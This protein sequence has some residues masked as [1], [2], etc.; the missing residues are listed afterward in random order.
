LTNDELRKAIAHQIANDPWYPQYHLTLVGLVCNLQSLHFKGR[1][2]YF[3][4]HRGEAMNHNEVFR[5]LA[6]D[7]LVSW[8]IKPAP[9]GWPHPIWPNGTLLVGAGGRPSIVGGYPITLATAEDD[10]L[11]TWKVRNDEV[12]ITQEH[13][14][15]VAEP[16]SAPG[17]VSWEEGVTWRAGEVFY[18]AGG[19]SHWDSVDEK[20]RLKRHQHDAAEHDF[21]L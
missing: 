19:G 11:T 6:S 14:R 13:P 12:R 10:D 4:V 1:H 8:E 20:G 5:H 9:L 16:R 7:D 18:M 2:H 17:K 15:Y 3:L 21:P